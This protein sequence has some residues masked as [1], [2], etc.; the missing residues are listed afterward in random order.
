[1]T[2]FMAMGTSANN[3]Y[4]NARDEWRQEQIEAGR[5][6]PSD[7]G[8]QLGRY[9]TPSKALAYL[10]G[11]AGIAVFFMVYKKFFAKLLAVG[12]SYGAF[13]W[14]GSGGRGFDFFNSLGNTAPLEFI[15]PSS[16]FS[17]ISLI[18]LIFAILLFCMRPNL[19][20]VIKPNNAMGEAVYIRADDPIKLR[21]A[22]AIGFVEVLPEPDSERAIREMGA[23]IRDIQELG[24]EGVRK[25]TSEEPSE[26]IISEATISEA[27]TEI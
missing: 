17:V 8:P 16:L 13:M 22:N 6:A 18:V 1:M 25:W 5:P 2:I 19:S 3:R 11:F 10:V 27:S 7:E 21:K 4:Q 26:A 12:T 23:M 15:V 14:L 9:Q 20:I 24:D